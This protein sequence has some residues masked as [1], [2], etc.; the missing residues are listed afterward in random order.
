MIKVV[1][2]VEGLTEQVFV[3]RIRKECAHFANWLGRI[4]ALTPLKAGA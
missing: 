2:V 1:V 3:R 4:E